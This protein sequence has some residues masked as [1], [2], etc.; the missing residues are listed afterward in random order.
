LEKVYPNP[1]GSAG[2]SLQTQMDL[3]EYFGHEHEPEAVAAFARRFPKFRD[4][5]C[6]ECVLNGGEVLF[7][8]Y[9]YWHQVHAPTAHACRTHG[10]RPP[11]TLAAHAAHELTRV[12]GVG[13]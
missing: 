11:H 13:G 2:I 8:P 9:G 1:L 5:A 4:V 10:T 12:W 6:Q 3:S 7:L